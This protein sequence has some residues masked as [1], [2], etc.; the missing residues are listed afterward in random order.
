MKSKK[1]QQQN[2]DHIP[3]RVVHGHTDAGL[4]SDT[5]VTFEP[6]QQANQHVAEEPSCSSDIL[7]ASE[8]DLTSEQREQLSAM[9][10]RLEPTRDL[11]DLSKAALALD[12]S[13]QSTQSRTLQEYF[14]QLVEPG[15]SV[16][17]SILAH[18]AS[19]DVGVVVR[20][21]TFRLVP[22]SLPKGIIT[23]TRLPLSK[24]N[25][26]ATEPSGQK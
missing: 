24:V 4:L 22:I 12:S 25:T 14:H 6:A 10:K 17:A 16:S 3:L 11:S 2:R 23:L 21:A 18:V 15:Q 1:T 20:W 13:L 9:I 26:G 5:V 7:L 8:S 19:C